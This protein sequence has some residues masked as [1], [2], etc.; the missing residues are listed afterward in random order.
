LIIVCNYEINKESLELKC[1]KESNAI[2][3][4]HCNGKCT[5][6]KELNDEDKKENIPLNSNKVDNE[7][8]LFTELYKETKF[9]IYTVKVHFKLNYIYPVSGFFPDPIFRPPVNLCS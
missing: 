1:C 9:K 4:K 8:Q 2:S 7:I 3:G 5:L 6:K